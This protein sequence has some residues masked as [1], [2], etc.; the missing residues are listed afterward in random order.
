MVDLLIAEKHLSAIPRIL[1]SNFE[2]SMTLTHHIQ[3]VGWPLKKLCSP[4]DMKSQ[5]EVSLVLSGFESGTTYWKHLDDEEWEEW[6]KALWAGPTG[7]GRR[8]G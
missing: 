5:M 7:C 8:E 1:Y 6:R 3:L 2:K 4:N